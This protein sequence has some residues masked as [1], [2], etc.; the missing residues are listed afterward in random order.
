MGIVR[1]GQCVTLKQNR[2]GTP[3]DVARVS[4]FRVT[5]EHH[6]PDDI[7]DIGT[8]VDRDFVFHAE[9]APAK[10]MITEDLTKPVVA[11]RVIRV[12]ER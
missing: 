2:L 7:W 4:S 8:L 1:L 9:I 10:P 11:S 5:A 3:A 6:I 12:L